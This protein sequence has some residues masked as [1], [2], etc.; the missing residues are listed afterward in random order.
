MLHR[1]RPPALAWA[2]PLRLGGI[3][4]YQIACDACRCIA[5][6]PWYGPL[7]DGGLPEDGYMAQDC[8]ECQ[9]PLVIEVGPDWDW[10]RTPYPDWLQAQL[11]TDW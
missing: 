2:V 11:D 5:W 9:H 1:R 6:Q 8:P 4:G 7:P 3:I 10:H